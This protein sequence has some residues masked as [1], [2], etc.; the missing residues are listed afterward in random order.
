MVAILLV[1][2]GFFNVS[3]ATTANST[4][5]I[6][7]DDKYRGRVMSVYSLIFAG[8]SPIGSLLTGSMS[9]KYGTSNTFIICGVA[10]AHTSS[11]SE[12]KFYVYG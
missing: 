2:V 8:A 1:I 5:Q 3:F 12:Y 10:V 9:D 6:N 11:F 4:M 7:A